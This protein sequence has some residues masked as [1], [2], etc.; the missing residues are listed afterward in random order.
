VLNCSR[1]YSRKGARMAVD[2]MRKIGELESPVQ[3]VEIY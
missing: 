1:F 3:I 2:R